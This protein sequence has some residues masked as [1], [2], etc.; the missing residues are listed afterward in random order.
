MSRVTKSNMFPVSPGDGM[1]DRGFGNPKL[2]SQS[3]IGKSIPR[4][5]ADLSHIILGQFMGCVRLTLGPGCT[6]LCNFVIHIIKPASEKVVCWITAR[7][8][9]AF[10]KQANSFWHRFSSGEFPSHAMREN[11]LSLY[12]DSSISVDSASNPRPAIIWTAFFN[13]LPKTI[14]QWNSF[15]FPRKF[16]HTPVVFRRSALARSKSALATFLA[17]YRRSFFNLIHVI[18]IHNRLR[19]ST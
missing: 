3:R 16:S 11:A 18:T 8:V 17:K 13:L 9:V 15:S 14:R 19:M 4:Q 1:T 6:A 10:V 5:V 2:I 12:I 7:R